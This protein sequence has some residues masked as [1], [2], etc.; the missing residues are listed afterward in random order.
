M[1]SSIGE[2]IAE[3]AANE[4][5]DN[6]PPSPPPQRQAS[7]PIEPAA[8]AASG[9]R[10]APA[11]ANGGG[12]RG[13]GSGAGGK[14][15]KQQQTDASQRS[16]TTFFSRSPSGK[17][18]TTAAA[19]IPAQHVNPTAQVVKTGHTDAVVKQEPPAAQLAK[20]SVTTRIEMLSNCNLP[21]VRGVSEEVGEGCCGLSSSLSAPEHTPLCLC[22]AGP[23][24]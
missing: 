22:R 12:K 17:V 9:K 4:A 1:H 11:P 16:I 14:K 7:A 15:A 6:S 5:A 21:S 13:I 19:P 24:P 18:G 8:K 2:R 23:M 3:A 20:V 10:K